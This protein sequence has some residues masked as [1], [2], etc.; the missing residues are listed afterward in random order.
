MISGLC[1][2]LMLLTGLFPFGGIALPMASGALILVMVVE[3]G[4][5][6]ALVVYAAVAAL[7]MLISPDRSAAVLFLVFFGYYP[8]VKQKLEQLPSRLI[9]LACKLALFTVTIAVSYLVVIYVFGLT[10]L[11]DSFGELAGYALLFAVG[12]GNILCLIYDYILT[13]C[14]TLYVGWFRPNFLQR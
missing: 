2:V 7:A 8:V 12:L 4:H 9:E 6:P 5:R 11:L 14:Y 1:A 13:R 3:L 10:D